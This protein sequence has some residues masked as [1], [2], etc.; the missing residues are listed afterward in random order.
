M[1]V[2]EQPKKADPFPF[3]KATKKVEPQKKVEEIKK[4]ESPPQPVKKVTTQ[5]KK[6]LF[7]ED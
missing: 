1:P 5:P 4:Q 6:N 2:A 3:A 7:E